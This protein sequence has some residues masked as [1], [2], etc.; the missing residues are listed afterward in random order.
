MVQ[1][2]EPQKPI[3]LSFASLGFKTDTDLLKYILDYEIHN[4]GCVS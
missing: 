2:I 3:H 4:Q 1:S